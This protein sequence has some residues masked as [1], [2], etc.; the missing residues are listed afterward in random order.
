M[1]TNPS[2]D[3]TFLGD[4]SLICAYTVTK[5]IRY[6]GISTAIFTIWCTLSLSVNRGKTYDPVLSV[7]SLSANKEL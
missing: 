1:T 5:T 4:D 7:Y 2:I 6:I 3:K